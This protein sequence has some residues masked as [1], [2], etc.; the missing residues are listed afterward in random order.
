MLIGGNVYSFAHYKRFD[1]TFD[2]EFTLDEKLQEKL[3]ELRGDTDIIVYLQ[4][5]SGQCVH[6][7]RRIRSGRREDH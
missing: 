2:R 5:V 7:R 3:K 4:H 6:L 1:L